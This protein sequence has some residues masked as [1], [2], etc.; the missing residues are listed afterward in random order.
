M[1]WQFI[2]ARY[3]VCLNWIQFWRK[4]F[5]IKFLAEFLYARAWFGWILLLCC[6]VVIVLDGYCNMI[7]CNRNLK[8]AECTFCVYLSLG[9]KF[10]SL[11]CT[12]LYGIGRLGDRCWEQLERSPKFQDKSRETPNLKGWHRG[13]Q[14]IGHSFLPP[15]IDL[16][17]GP[18][19]TK[20]ALLLV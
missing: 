20:W 17:N 3:G 2:L 7:F 5:Q 13:C 9:R 12:W 4:F 10:S 11:P 15:Q 1:E 6:C 16:V 8:E 19:L 18:F 14:G